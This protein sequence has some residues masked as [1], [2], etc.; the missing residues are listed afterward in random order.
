MDYELDLADRTHLDRPISAVHRA[1]LLEDRGDDTV[2]VVEVS[3]QF[4]RPGR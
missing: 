3:E 2:P 4:L 1:A